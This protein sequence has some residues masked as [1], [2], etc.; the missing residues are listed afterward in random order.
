MTL[1]GPYSGNE[2]ILVISIVIDSDGGHYYEHLKK[3]QFMMKIEL[4]TCISM[5]VY[6]M[7]FELLEMAKK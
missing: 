5:F 1:R 4:M 2:Q 3:N 7:I 6:A